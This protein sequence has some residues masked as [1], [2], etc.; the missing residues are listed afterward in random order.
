MR[1]ACRVEKGKEQICRDTSFTAKNGDSLTFRCT[2]LSLT[3]T[4]DFFS[5]LYSDFHQQFNVYPTY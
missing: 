2:S 4:V 1:A 3:G 5:F